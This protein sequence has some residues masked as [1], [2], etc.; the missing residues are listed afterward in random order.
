MDQLWDMTFDFDGGERESDGIGNES[1]YSSDKEDDVDEPTTP[2]ESDEPVTDESVEEISPRAS[3][4]NSPTGEQI[5]LTIVNAHCPRSSHTYI[6]RGSDQSSITSFGSGRS[7][8]VTDDDTSDDGKWNM[9]YLQKKRRLLKRATEFTD[10]EEA[11]DASIARETISA[12]LHDS[13]LWREAKDLAAELCP[14]KP[15]SP[16]KPNQSGLQSSRP[17]KRPRI[18]LSSVHHVSSRALDKDVILPKNHLSES[19]S[20][21][22]LPNTF[23]SEGAWIVKALGIFWNR[24][25]AAETTDDQGT[26]W[27][28]LKDP[29]SGV[30]STLHQNVNAASAISLEQAISCTPVAQ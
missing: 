30:I 15:S 6:A 23:Y 11:Y 27:D 12:S 4:H 26:V 17:N 25:E 10:L 1:G 21:I 13:P 29:H 20:K 28:I 14:G 8:P 7:L 24:H 19:C 5:G 22:V 18:D 2:E 3:D 9:R 16:P